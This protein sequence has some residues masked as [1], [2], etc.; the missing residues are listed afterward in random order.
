MS[1]KRKTHS[2]EFKAKVA[3]EAIK[4]LKT[5]SELASQH[6][7]HPVQI[8]TWKR[9]ALE[10]GPEAFKRGSQKSPPSEEALTAPLFEEIGL[11]EAYVKRSGQ[12]P[13]IVL[14]D[15]TSSSFE[16]EHNEL[17]HYGY[18]RDG[19]KGQKQMVIG[20][21]TGADGE[22][23]AVRVFEGNTTDPSTVGE[24]IA[25]LKEQFGVS[26][27]VLIGDRGM[28]KAKGKQALGAHGWR[29]IRALTKPQIRALIQGGVLQPDLFDEDIGEG[30]Q[31]D[32]RL[33]V[34]RN[35]RVD[36]AGSSELLR[37]FQSA[38][39]PPAPIPAAK[40]PCTEY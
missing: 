35:E 1:S 31:G 25:L 37:D 28:I 33:I 24:Q 17:A 30:V 29:Y 19:K 20:L 36:M 7:V 13:A 4:G 39:S 5:A 27:V 8:S 14:Y 16:G 40:R 15:V 22:P 11:Y 21:L 38:S 18:N 12:P 10:A 3:V 23:L 32:K 26:E 9:Q 2:P 6:Q 34:R